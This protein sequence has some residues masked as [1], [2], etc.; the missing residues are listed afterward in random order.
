MVKLL[1]SIMVDDAKLMVRRR[2]RH[3]AMDGSAKGDV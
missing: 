3:C 2:G 1:K